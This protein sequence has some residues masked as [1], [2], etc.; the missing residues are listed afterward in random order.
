MKHVLF[1][2]IGGH[3]NSVRSLIDNEKYDKISCKKI[4]LPLT[5][6]NINKNKKILSNFIKNNKKYKNYIFISIGSNYIRFVIYKFLNENFKS[7]FLFPT[8]ISKYAY[9]SENVS[10]GAGSVIM[11]GVSI[12]S[13]SKIGSHC[14][15][16]T[17]SSIDHDNNIKNFSS[18]GPGVNTG[19]GVKVSTLSHIGIGSSINHNVFIEKNVIIGGSSF[20]NRNCL[21]NSIYFGVPGKFIKKRKLDDDYL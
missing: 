13:N 21:R 19:G 7:K 1:I 5:K 4:Y 18:L 2:G 6:E 20:I 3:Y 8:I 14:I 10:I 11:S 16:N 17:N 15:I 9:I 12:N